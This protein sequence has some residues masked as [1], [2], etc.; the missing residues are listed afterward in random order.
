MENKTTVL[1]KT[2]EDWEEW[3]ELI[4][5]AALALDIWNLI[6]PAGACIALIEPV[7]STPNDIRPSSTRHPTPFSTLTRD[8]AEE[9]RDQKRE[10]RRQLDRYNRRTLA[11][12]KIR[13][14]IQ[15]TIA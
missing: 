7:Q 6:D 2:Q 1:L 14:K 8:E 3:I 13:V 12:A 10:Y 4:K 5:T 9:Y 11:L 15:E